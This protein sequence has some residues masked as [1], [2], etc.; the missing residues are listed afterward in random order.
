MIQI[1]PDDT[2]DKSSEELQDL[3]SRGVLERLLGDGNSLPLKSWST[4]DT[5][6]KVGRTT[7]ECGECMQSVTRKGTGAS[8][9]RRGLWTI[10]QSLL[11]HYFLGTV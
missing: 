6:S 5:L 7:R 11:F 9:C 10:R 1:R 2:C 3:V 8:N 4:S